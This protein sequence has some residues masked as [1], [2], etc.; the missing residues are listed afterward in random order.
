[1]D[2]LIIKSLNFKKLLKFNIMFQLLGNFISLS[3]QEIK[4][5]QL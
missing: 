1:M 4:K 2:Q 5:N 3:L